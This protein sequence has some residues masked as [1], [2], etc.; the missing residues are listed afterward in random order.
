MLQSVTRCLLYPSLKP[1]SL[2]NLILGIAIPKA[3]FHYR[4][5]LIRQ[6]L[7]LKLVPVPKVVIIA[8]N[9]SFMH[10][11]LGNEP[12]ERPWSK[13][14]MLRAEAQSVSAD[15]EDQENTSRTSN[16]SSERMDRLEGL[17]AGMTQQQA[18]FMANQLQN[19]GKLALRTEFAPTPPSEHS[20]NGSSAFTDFIKARDR[21]MR[22]GSLYEPA[23]ND[24]PTEIPLMPP[25]NQPPQTTREPQP[26]TV[27]NFVPPENH[28]YKIPN[29]RDLDWPT[30][31]R[32][33]R[34]EAYQGVGADFKAFGMQFL[35]RLGAAQLMS[36]GD[37]PEEY[38]I[39][40]SM[41]S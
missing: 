19:Q 32:F 12:T 37:W 11:Q 20:S 18:L 17:I 4:N 34:R 15:F 16:V 10:L 30:F 25:P 22:M 1:Y 29:P 14:R 6:S 40:A 2:C 35:Q 26:Q 27:Q 36:G 5:S 41:E 33:S 24:A 13:D 28:G 3:I 8:A 39:L 38:K 7:L 21:R 9:R 23:N 31:A